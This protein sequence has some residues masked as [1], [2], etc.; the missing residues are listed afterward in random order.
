MA[1][2]V[3]TTCG[4]ATQLLLSGLP[5]LQGPGIVTPYT[6]DICGPIREQLEKNG[7]TMVE[8]KL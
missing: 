4:I 5:S 2:S 3:G 8:R 1:K 6:E 7:L